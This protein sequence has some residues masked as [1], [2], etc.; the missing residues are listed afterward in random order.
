[1]DKKA[2]LMASD[3]EGDN[4]LM[5]AI[6]QNHLDVVTWPKKD[7]RCRSGGRTVTVGVASKRDNPSISWMSC[8]EYVYVRMSL[9]GLYVLAITP[10]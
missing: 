8:L 1:M 3:L 7:P 2:D 4:V 6:S 9:W 5:M 10:R